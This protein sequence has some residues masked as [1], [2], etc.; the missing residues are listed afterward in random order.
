MSPTTKGGEG[1]PIPPHPVLNAILVCDMAI[2]EEGTGKVSLIGIFENINATSFPT[3]HPELSVYAKLTDADG[4]YVLRLELIQLEKARIIAS[5]E[6]TITPSDR[7][8]AVE[9]NF[10]LHNLVFPEAG[11]YEFRLSANGKHVGAKTLR[12]VR[13]GSS[14]RAE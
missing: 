10:N 4:E 3:L 7:M 5:G 12:M 2:R 6:T 13:S 11:L 1:Q 9:L 14:A 8:G